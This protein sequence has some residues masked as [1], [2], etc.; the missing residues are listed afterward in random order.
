[1]E[2]KLLLQGNSESEFYG[3]GY[4]PELG[5]LN[6]PQVFRSWNNLNCGIPVRVQLLP[7][8][9]ALF[10]YLTLAKIPEASWK[11]WRNQQTML[12]ASTT[13]TTLPVPRDELPTAAFPSQETPDSCQF[14]QVV[15]G[16]C[17][18]WFFQCCF[19]GKISEQTSELPLR[20]FE[21]QRSFSLQ[22]NPAS[23]LHSRCLGSFWD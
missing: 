11:G 15:K 4:G 10:P 1:M 18:D 14:W 17:R 20:K 23:H 12:S 16:T 5:F 8:P 6:W 19:L 21:S 13:S 22:E 9:S 2:L 7:G 3:H